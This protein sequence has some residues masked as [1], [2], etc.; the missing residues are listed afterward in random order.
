[1]KEIIAQPGGHMRHIE[2]PGE[3]LQ[4]YADEGCPIW[5]Y[6]RGH[7]GYYTIDDRDNLGDVLR[8]LRGAV[9]IE[10]FEGGF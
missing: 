1:M 7:N 9:Q 4:L 5:Y 2:T 10:V 3:A 6:D 8:Q